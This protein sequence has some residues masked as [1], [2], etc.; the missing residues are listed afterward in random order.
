VTLTLD[1]GSD[2]VIRWLENQTGVAYETLK[3]HYAKFLPKVDRDAWGLIDPRVGTDKLD[4]IRAVGGPISKNV[5]NYAAARMRGG[6]LEPDGDA[7][8]CWIFQGF[9]SA[10]VR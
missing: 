2:R 4:P 9:V 8:R 3:K 6:G 5:S 7:R 1:T 10:R